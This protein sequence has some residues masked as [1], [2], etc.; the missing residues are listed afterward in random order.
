MRLADLFTC[1]AILDGG[2]SVA[3]DGMKRGEWTGCNEP[4]AMLRLL[5]DR[6]R[7]SERKARFFTAACCRRHWD[8][9]PDEG[10]RA[11]E[12]VERHADLLAHREEL[13]A[14]RMAFTGT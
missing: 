2:P 1:T 5:R 12:A 9:F 7:V 11:V 6:G 8:L 13:D 4:A 14:A 3:K 10:R